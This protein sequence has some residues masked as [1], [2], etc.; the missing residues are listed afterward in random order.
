MRSL[1]PG[2]RRG[3]SMIEVLIALGILSVGALAAIGMFPAMARLHAST[4]DTTSR[5]YVAQQKMDELLSDNVF[6]S[7]TYATDQ[8]FR[9]GY[10]RWRGIP[11]AY[12]S[13]SVQVIEVEVAW[14]DG[15]RARN[16]LLY[17]QVAP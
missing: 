13:A 16:I 11:D 15:G 1:Q 9:D 8:P 7:Q 5:M 17:G 4:V 14:V 2:R 10:R 6:I 3:M 12:G